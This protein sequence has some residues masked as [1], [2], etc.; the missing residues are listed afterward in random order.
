MN[1]WAGDDE[2]PAHR[3]DGLGPNLLF[4][5]NLARYRCLERF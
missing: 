3:L 2:L 1:L 5:P 4:L